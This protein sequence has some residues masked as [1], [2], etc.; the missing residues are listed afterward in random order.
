MAYNA[1]GPRSSG[2]N[3]GWSPVVHGEPWLAHDRFVIQPQAI[4]ITFM[5]SVYESNSTPPTMTS[6]TTTSPHPPPSSHIPKF[7]SNVSARSGR[8]PWLARTYDEAPDLG[9]ASTTTLSWVSTFTLQ[10]HYYGSSTPPARRLSLAST[11]AHPCRRTTPRRGR[12][13]VG[14]PTSATNSTSW[15]ASVGWN[16]P[17]TPSTPCLI[18]D[19]MMAFQK[20]ILQAMALKIWNLT[21]WYLGQEGDGTLEST[22]P[23]K[24]R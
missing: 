2:L 20:H 8:L 3:L 17:C 1:V 22:H 18:S 23:L 4:L 14:S 10:H 21:N 7:N 12:D 11:P 16:I 19:V 13:Q 15:S 24:F 6:S 5:S 9:S